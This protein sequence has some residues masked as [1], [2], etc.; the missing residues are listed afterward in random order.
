LRRYSGFLALPRRN[1]TREAPGLPAR[2]RKKVLPTAQGKADH[3]GAGASKTLE[4]AQVPLASLAQGFL[5]RAI[6]MDK[7]RHSAVSGSQAGSP[8]Q[9]RA[10]AGRG[11]LAVVASVRLSTCKNW[12]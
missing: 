12:V 1:R 3:S 9:E 4:T 10:R 8:V 6:W 11:S 2:E 5:G 7:T